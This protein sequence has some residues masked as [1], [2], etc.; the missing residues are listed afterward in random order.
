MPIKLLNE[1]LKIIKEM[2]GIWFLHSGC[3]DDLFT[4]ITDST[5]PTRTILAVD[6]DEKHKI[7][8]PLN[9]LLML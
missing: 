5:E 8:A 6:G 2:N 3:S 4:L 9:S 1:W 7:L